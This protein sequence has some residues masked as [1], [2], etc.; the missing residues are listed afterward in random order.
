MS[1]YENSKAKQRK[2]LNDYLDPLAKTTQFVDTFQKDWVAK[3]Q[4]R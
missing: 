2:Y 1:A 3:Q 4:L